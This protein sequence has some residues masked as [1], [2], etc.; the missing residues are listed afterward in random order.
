MPR[1]SVL[2]VHNILLEMIRQDF[3]VVIKPVNGHPNGKQSDSGHVWQVRHAGLLGIKYEV[4]VRSD[5][6]AVEP[7]KV[8]AGL[9]TE[10]VEMG[11][12]TTND[13]GKEV[14]KGVVDAAVLGC[15]RL[16]AQIT[17]TLISRNVVSAI[18]MMM[19]A[20]LRRRVCFPWPHISSISFQKNWVEFLQSCGAA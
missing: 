5:L 17:R 11:D 20:R 9:K 18:E 7:V 10:D 6:F 16:K 4:A 1:R 19:S 12:S 2:H 14:L 8:E 3:P 13:Q 15:V